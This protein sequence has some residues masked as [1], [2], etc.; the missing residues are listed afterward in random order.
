MAR[1]PWKDDFERSL[2]EKKKKKEFQR[3]KK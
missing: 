1:G 3:K 2:P